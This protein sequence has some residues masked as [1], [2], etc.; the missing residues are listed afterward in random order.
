MMITA[1]ESSSFLYWLSDT[2]TGIHS[3]DDALTD[4]EEE[5][6]QIHIELGDTRPDSPT[7]ATSQSYRSDTNN[8]PSRR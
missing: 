2:T 4:G 1:A 8:I 5:K 6:L 7:V 3:E